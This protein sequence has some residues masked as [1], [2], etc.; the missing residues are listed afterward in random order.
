MDRGQGV[1]IG[2]GGEE[3][4]SIVSRGKEVTHTE[5]SLPQPKPPQKGKK[6]LSSGPEKQRDSCSV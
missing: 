4:T 3:K 5:E 2:E 6:G 1:V